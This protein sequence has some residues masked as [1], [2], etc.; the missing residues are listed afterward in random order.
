MPPAAAGRRVRI[1][2]T[3]SEALGCRG[4]A[5]PAQCR[6]KVAAGAAETLE[7]LLAGN[8]GALFD[9]GTCQSQALRLR[10]AGAQGAH[11]KCRN[12]N[13]DPI[14]V[15]SSSISWDFLLCSH[16]DR[17]I[18]TFAGAGKMAA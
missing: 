7:H 18:P 5:A 12:P 13:P 10:N 15:N 9:V 14:H 17:P 11:S 2:N 4:R 8:G 1:V 16:S 3:E 6:R